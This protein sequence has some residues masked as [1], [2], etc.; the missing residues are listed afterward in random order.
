MS[1]PER[2]K[3]KGPQVQAG[4]WTG[5]VGSA[6]QGL[7]GQGGQGRAGGRLGPREGRSWS[8]LGTW[9]MLPGETQ[10]ACWPVLHSGHDAPAAPVCPHPSEKCTQRQCALNLSLLEKSKVRATRPWSIW[11]NRRTW[12]ATWTHTR[13]DLSSLRVCRLQGHPRPHR[14]HWEGLLDDLL[15]RR[16]QLGA[17]ASWCG[18]LG[19]LAHR[20][21]GPKLH[22]CRSG[23]WPGAGRCAGTVC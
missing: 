7:Q 9:E 5:W 2:G 16:P 22:L 8:L 13:G 17:C 6:V 23:T 20:P 10:S 18:H 4:L 14:G 19:L 21:T 15:P 3:E 11:S 1:G 12:H